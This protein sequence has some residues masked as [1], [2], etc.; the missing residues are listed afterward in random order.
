V[1][2]QKDQDNTTSLQK[3]YQH[4]NSTNGNNSTHSILA[5]TNLAKLKEHANANPI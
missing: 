3:I 2:N 1:T 4:M 5:V